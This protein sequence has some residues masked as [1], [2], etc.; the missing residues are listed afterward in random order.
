MFHSVV[1][2]FAILTV[3]ILLQLVKTT[4]GPA[5]GASVA[6]PAMTA[7]AVSF[8][9][10]HL[11]KEENGLWTSLGPNWTSPWSVFLFLCL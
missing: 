10:G 3:L 11:N 4:G 2:L 8:L 5:L 7:G 1:Y 6:S 9:Q